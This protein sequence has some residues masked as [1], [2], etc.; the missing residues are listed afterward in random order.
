MIALSSALLIAGA[1]A[2]FAQTATSPAPSTAPRTQMTTPPAATARTDMASPT[3]RQSASLTT[4]DAQKLGTGWRA[5]KIHGTS[6]YNDQNQKVGSIDDLI[7]NRDDHVV[8][9]VVSVGGF[10]GMG[11]HLVAVPYDQL[12]INADAKGKVDKIMLRGATKDSLKAMP[13]FKYANG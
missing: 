9:A 12:Q 10:L 2:G 1:G 5:S 4:A 6:V 13:E 8:Y 7:I 11:N 3:A